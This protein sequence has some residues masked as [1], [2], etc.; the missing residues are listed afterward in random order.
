MND[1]KQSLIL[2]CIPGTAVL[3]Y[4]FYQ[5]RLYGLIFSKSF[6]FCFLLV[7][8]FGRKYPII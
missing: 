2:Q 1:S 8:L 7:P 5:W 6:F 4:M 3:Q